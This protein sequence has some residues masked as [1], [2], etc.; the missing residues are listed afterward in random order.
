MMNRGITGIDVI[1]AAK[2]AGFDDVATS[3]LGMMKLRV[4]GDHLH[5]SAIVDSNFHV[6]SAVNDRND[7]AGPGT[8]YMMSAE[9]W[10]Q[11]QNIPNAFEASDFE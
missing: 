6:I 7:Y 11:V 4:S 2:N 8:G 9:R 3:L 5:T 1:K 10:N